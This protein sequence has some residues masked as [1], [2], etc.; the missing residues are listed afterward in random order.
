MGVCTRE[1]G[2]ARPRDE[3]RR[4][5]LGV[6][7]ALRR[8][9]DDGFGRRRGATARSDVDGARGRAWDGSV[10]DGATMKRRDGGGF[11]DIMIDGRSRATA[12][13]GAARGGWA[14]VRMFARDD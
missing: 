6:D 9:R 7:G 14:R 8:A 13:V 12:F 10:F 11:V 5:A 4:I 3:R 2:D 1:Y